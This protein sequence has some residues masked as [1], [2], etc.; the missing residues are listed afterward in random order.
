MAYLGED[1]EA[2]RFSN[3]F[4]SIILDLVS[5]TDLGSFPP[6]ANDPWPA[7]WTRF[8]RA[9]IPR[10]YRQGFVTEAGYQPLN[11]AVFVGIVPMTYPVRI[12]DAP[13]LGAAFI[14]DSGGHGGAGGVRGQV[15]RI[16]AA[17]IR[18]GAPLGDDS[19]QV[20]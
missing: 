12:I 15:I 2:I 4:F 19:F 9:R 5:L 3:P 7:Q 11:E 8:R 6:D 16:N 1:V 18:A 20:R 17:G 10:G 13:E 14:V